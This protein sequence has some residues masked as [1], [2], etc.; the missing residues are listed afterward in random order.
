MDIDTTKLPA[1]LI[2][3]TL[4]S[5]VSVSP[6]SPS[7]PSRPGGPGGPAGPAGPGGPGGPT[8]SLDLDGVEVGVG[9]IEAGG[10]TGDAPGCPARIIPV[11]CVEPV[12]GP[13]RYRELHE[14][15]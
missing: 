14:H 11:H 3:S 4:T 10:V 15:E 9:K 8:G 1:A 2:K 12:S 13:S 6:I 7:P 5:I